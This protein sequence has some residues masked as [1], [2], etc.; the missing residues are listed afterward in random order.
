MALAC[1]EKFRNGARPRF[2]VTVLAELCYLVPQLTGWRVR[3][4]PQ[5]VSG[6]VE[7]T[8]PTDV[9]VRMVRGLGVSLSVLLEVPLPGRPA[10]SWDAVWQA[11]AEGITA[12]ERGGETGWKGCGTAVR[13]ALDEWRNIDGER[14]DMGPGW[15][16]PSRDDREARTRR[17]R[18]DNIRWHLREY[19]HLAAHTG[20]EHWTR[21]DAVLMLSTC[22]ALLALRNP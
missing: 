21:D 1:Y 15:T 4:E 16:P 7:I 20:A 14:E 13:L 6:D 17:Q 19:A 9:W 10:K 22:A 5:Q 2:R 18:L 11:L 12:F 8:Y 3:T